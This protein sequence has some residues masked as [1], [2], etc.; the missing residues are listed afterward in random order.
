[1]KIVAALLAVIPMQLTQR[2]PSDQVLVSVGTGRIDAPDSIAA[3]WRHLRVEEDGAGHILVVF[4]ML[5]RTSSATISAFLAAVD[6]ARVTP[7]PA[8]ALGGPEIGDTGVVVIR[9]TPGRYVLAC[10]R[11]G[12]DGHRHSRS[13]E[14]KVVVVTSASPLRWRASPPKATE[15]VRMVDF[16]YT[17]AE[18]WRAGVHMLHVVNEGKQDHQLRIARLRPGSTMADW[19]RAEQPGRHVIPTAGIARLGPKMSAYLPVT[20]T[21][22]DYVLHCLVTDPATEKIH[23]HLGM[24]RAIRVE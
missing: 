2:S 13:G 16:A 1:M 4:R 3:G 19:M 17:G 6:T 15:R 21:A 5:G 7:A 18:R 12:E 24:V 10:V 22:G 14:A 23:A 8:V 9:F 11:K 20:V